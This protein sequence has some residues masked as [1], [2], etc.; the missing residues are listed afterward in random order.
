[1][2]IITIENSDH[3]HGLRAKVI[4]SSDVACLFDASPYAT[5]F[6]LW[7]Q[8]AGNV[9]RDDS[10]DNRMTW[11][12]RLEPAI[13]AG[14]A[15]DMRWK[16]ESAAKDFYRHDSLPLG[17]TLDF[18]VVDHEW[19][20]GVV[21]I[22]NVDWLE[23]KEKWTPQ[24]AP[25]HIELQVQHQFICTGFT[26][27]V[28]GCFIGGNEL[29]IYERRPLSKIMAEIEQRSVDFW[30]SI[31]EQRAPD[32]YGTAA[33]FAVLKELYPREAPGRVIES[34]DPRLAEAASMYM[35]SA[36][37]ESGGKRAK[38]RYKVALLHA[39]QDAVLLKLP[40]F[41]VKRKVNKAGAVSIEVKPLTLG[42][43]TPID[44]SVINAG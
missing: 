6:T 14:L 3:W 18:R 20:P 33:E 39:L 26:W 37:Q 9:E 17:A 16:I 22:K 11:G 12:K 4:G 2:T 35:Y 40:D 15:E 13:A 30:Q 43:V 19:G 1:M 34:E 5:R 7:H 38:E 8:K 25:D 27:G 42:S 31:V 21:E 41:W 44:P 32:P 28:I 29:R 24:R 36:E 10:G 23:W